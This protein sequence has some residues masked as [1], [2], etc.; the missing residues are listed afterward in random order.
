MNLFETMLLPPCDLSGIFLQTAKYTAMKGAAEEEE[1][2]E[3]EEE[4]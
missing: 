1:E 3:E 4:S 2:E